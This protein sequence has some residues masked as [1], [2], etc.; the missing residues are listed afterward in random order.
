MS[1]VVCAFRDSLPDDERRG[2]EDKL[3]AAWSGNPNYGH[4][5]PMGRDAEGHVVWATRDEARRH[6]E[7]KTWDA[8]RPRA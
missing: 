7:R 3:N 6:W 5:V 2:F 4:L 1:C 8:H